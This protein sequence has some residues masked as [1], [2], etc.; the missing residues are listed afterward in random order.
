MLV[1]VAIYYFYNQNEKFTKITP[2]THD[3][4]MFGVE[5]CPH[6]IKAKPMFKSLH[7]KIN[8]IEINPGHKIRL[9][10]IDCTLEKNKDLVEKHK[11]DG[12][13]TFILTKSDG[14]NVLYKLR[15]SSNGLIQFIKS[16]CK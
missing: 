15:P 13:P 11:I 1:L 12:V 4:Y 8:N 14:K 6:C 3:L 9:H 2:Q 16:N 5:D 7:K 10:Y